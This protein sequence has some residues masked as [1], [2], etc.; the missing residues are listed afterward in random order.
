[1]QLKYKMDPQIPRFY[2]FLM[3]YTR[4]VIIMGIS[5]ITLRH[6]EILVVFVVGVNDSNDK[7]KDHIQ[8]DYE[9]RPVSEW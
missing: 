9:C 4:L 1:M 5:F 6:H 3:L 8:D 2:K 7:N